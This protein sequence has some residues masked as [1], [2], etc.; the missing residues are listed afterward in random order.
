MKLE[1]PNMSFLDK[2]F[3]KEN[4]NAVMQPLYDAVIREGRR[5]FWYEEGAVPDSLDGRFDMIAAVFSLVLIRLE[6]DEASNQQASWLTE[7]FITDMDGQLRQ[8]GIG[9]M[10]VGKHVKRMMGALGGRI[11]AYRESMDNR[12]QLVEALKRNLYRGEE[13]DGKGADF[14]ASHLL[15]FHTDLANTSIANIISGQIPEIAK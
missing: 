5:I 6:D 13:P 12:G 10:V 9:D 4:P 7:L 14:V 11:G 8:S 2:L 3:S 15:R 1:H